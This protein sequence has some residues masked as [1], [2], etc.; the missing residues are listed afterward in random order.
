MEQNA[1]YTIEMEFQRRAAALKAEETRDRKEHSLHVQDLEVQKAELR[2]AAEAKIRKLRRE[3]REAV[4]DRKE[5]LNNTLQSMTDDTERLN[6][7]HA[8]QVD[9]LEF[10]SGCD[11]DVDDV[12][13][14][15]SSD[16]TSIRRELT[17]ANKLLAEQMEEIATRREQLHGW[18]YEEM[19]KLKLEKTQ[20][21]EQE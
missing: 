16:M 18:R 5:I 6:A 14:K 4:L 2:L 11:D 3:C 15:L 1:L 21:N 17:F 19:M 12:R 9:V 10:R 8:C 13:N 7:H 20:D